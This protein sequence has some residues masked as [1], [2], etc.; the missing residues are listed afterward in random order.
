VIYVS[1]DGLLA[2]SALIASNLVELM[3]W[4]QQMFT[5]Q[6]G[7]QVPSYR[8]SLSP[9]GQALLDAWKNG[10]QAAAVQAMAVS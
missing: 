7:F 3:T 2:C 6:L 9:R 10:D 8:L 5:Q 4:G 1:G